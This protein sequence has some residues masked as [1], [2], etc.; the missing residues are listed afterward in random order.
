VVWRESYRP[1]GERLTKSAAAKANDVWFTSRRLDSTGLVYM[2]ARYYDPVTGR[3]VSTDPKGFDEGNVQSF[4][5]YE[6]A[7]D[8]PY[9]Y[10]DPDG[11]A[12]LA[13]EGL[14]VAGLV[15]CA[16]EP[17]EARLRQSEALANGMKAILTWANSTEN[18]G[19]KSPDPASGSEL[20]PAD[21]SGELSKAG[22]AQQKHGDRE[23]GPYRRA[24]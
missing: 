23:G 19:A 24:Q 17:R 20:D 12:S 6:Y 4:N 1:Y 3:F 13:I 5:R 16:L 21:K 15:I 2:G 11:K 10:V 18:D 9:R 7:N 22:R 8:N 14:V